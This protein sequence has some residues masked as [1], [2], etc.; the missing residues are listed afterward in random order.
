MQI[1]FAGRTVEY[2]PWKPTAGKVFEKGFALDCE[3]SRIDDARPWLT[4]AF[5]LGA[6]SDGR[7]GVFLTREHAPAF[8]AAHADIPV[9]MHN[10]SFDL[11]VLSRLPLGEDIYD[12]VDACRVWDTQLLHRLLCLATEGHTAGLKGQSTLDHCVR[13]HLGVELTKDLVDSGGQSVRTSYGQWLNR[14]PREI[15]PV[16]LEYLAKDALATILVYR[17][18]RPA[19]KNALATACD[20]WGYVD[21]AWLDG[22]WRRWGPATHH[23]QLRA[24]IVLRAITVNGLH[25]DQDRREQLLSDLHAVAHEQQE[26]LHRHGY[27]P[28]QPGSGKALQHKLRRLHRTLPGHAIALTPTGRFATSEE[29]LAPLAE[30]E[31]FVKALLTYRAAE[32]LIATFVGKMGQAVLHPS[33]DVLK[34]TGRTSSFGAINAQNLPRDDRVRQCFVP[35]SGHV[36][37]NADYKTIE[38]VALAQAITSQF[39]SDS[40]LGA[41]LNEGKDPHTLV[42]AMATGKAATAISKEDRQRAKPINFGKPGGMGHETLRRYA[43]ASY[44]VNLTSEEVEALSNA[45][46]ELFPEMRMYLNDAT[47]LGW[48]TA[49]FFGLTPQ[50]HFEFTDSRKYL[51][52]SNV[53][54]YEERPHAILGWQ[55]LKVLRDL[56]PATRDGRPYDAETIAFFW[57]RVEERI[58]DLPPEHATAIRSHTPSP[59]L[60][61]AVARAIDRRPVWTLTG[62]LRARASFTARRNNVFQGLAADG[63]KLALWRLWRK[64]YRIVNFIHDEVL[65]EVAKDSDLDEHADRIRGLLIS[66]MREV[67]P[68]VQIDVDLVATS[69]WSKAAEKVVDCDGRL[70]VW[71]PQESPS[72][73]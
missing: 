35:S 42:A 1:D 52:H 39:G 6:A 70:L 3:T 71:S 18:I 38:L 33:F 17:R 68:E 40:K 44:H 2:S 22:Q 7:R 37:I 16:F 11:E 25:L 36:F 26:I 15:E 72:P 50:T 9:V 58:R 12:R 65:I 62:R 55:C 13:R 29:A 54:G 60:R 21:N 5:V 51:D 69:A 10:A 61:Q 43:A 34:T 73:A 53:R 28:G 63:A 23:I 46:F 27:L 64:G 32:K 59:A 67:I 14:D 30:V 57:A 20:A 31:P 41:I 8:L 56:S 19:L 24:A 49:R 47:D 45:W 66:G 4:P 48:E